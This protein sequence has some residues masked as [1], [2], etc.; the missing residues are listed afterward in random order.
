MERAKQAWTRRVREWKRRARYGRRNEDTHIARDRDESV[1]VGATK[2]MGVPV[3]S[4]PNEGRFTKRD[5]DFNLRD[6]IVT[7]PAGQVQAF[8]PGKQ[9]LFNEATCTSSP[10][11]RDCTT[12]KRR[13]LRISDDEMEQQ[14]FLRIVKSKPGRHALRNR[15]AV[16]HL[17]Q[18]QGDRYIGKRGNL[19]DLRRNAAVM[20]LE[21][22]HRELAPAA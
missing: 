22:V 16:E 17:Q 3:L 6:R 18:K 19:F 10:I 14:R 20:N 21:V 12:R 4:P 8:T 15:V 1:V 13:A 11:R 5:F 7:C 2:R 9:V